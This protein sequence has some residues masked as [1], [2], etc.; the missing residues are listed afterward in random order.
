MTNAECGA[1]LSWAL[2]RLGL[3][4]PAFRK[5][6]GQVCK[7]LRRRM[8]GLG[9]AG[10]DAYRS[11]LEAEA[12]EWRTL[13]D[14]CRI[15]ITR[16]CRDH[17]TW[18]RLRNTVLPRLAAESLDAGASAL[19]AWSA[20]CG[21]GE[22]PY[23]LRILWAL[24]LSRRFPGL[25]LKIVATDSDPV[26]LR[27]AHAAVYRRSSMREVPHAWINEA[28]EPSNG[29]LR[30]RPDYRA[31]I[32]F[33]RQNLRTAMPDGPFDL[34][35]CRYLAFTYF[36]MAGRRL[37]LQGIANRLRPGGILMLGANERPPPGPC[38]FAAEDRETGIWRRR[39]GA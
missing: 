37:A 13:E 11:V 1:F 26:M 3:H 31:D 7:R 17:D 27:R 21:G 32:H 34:V 16:F 6:R 35:L 39:G 2:P 8:R 18:V 24:A 38:P 9:V 5:V 30:L 29:L 36:D 22:E 15:T 4:P 23:S 19:R 14:C 12:D 25:Q 28:F 10:F 33:T 20:G